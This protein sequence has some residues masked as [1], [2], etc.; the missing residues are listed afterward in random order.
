MKK[1]DLSGMRFNRWAVISDS[2]QRVAAKVMWRCKCDCGAEGLVAAGNLK[3]GQSRSCGCLDREVA[4]KR[5]TTHGDADA[6]K[7]SPEL[8]AWYHINARCHNPV[9]KQYHDYGGRGIQ[10]CNEWRGV[11]GFEKFLG[12]IG[13]KPAPD[14]SIDRIDVNK[15]YEPGNVRW[16]DRTIQ[17][18]NKRLAK[19]N[20]SG[21]MG[22]WLDKRRNKWYAK[23]TAYGIQ[24][25]LCVT[26]DFFEACCARKSAELRLGVLHV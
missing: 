5:M 4:A 19:S 25:T 22:V 17:N 15:G 24:K 20:T 23:M 16:A 10:V 14:Y 2:G 9:D 21:V 12:H 3:S 1:Q 26:D 6:G 13:R 18:I 7:R 8:I 11:G